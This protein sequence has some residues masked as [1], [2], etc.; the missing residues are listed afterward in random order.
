MTECS[1]TFCDGLLSCSFKREW[2]RAGDAMIWLQM[3]RVGE[4]ATRFQTFSST[5]ESLLRNSSRSSLQLGTKIIS[6]IWLFPWSPAQAIDLWICRYELERERKHIFW[7]SPNFNAFAYIHTR[8]SAKVQI[9]H[10]IKHIR[11]GWDQCVQSHLPHPSYPPSH[12]KWNKA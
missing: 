11:S 7:T 3:R 1:L 5:V 6:H 4:L 8:N 10:T 2:S 12:I 9:I